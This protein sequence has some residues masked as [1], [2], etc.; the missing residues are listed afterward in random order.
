MSKPV[1]GLSNF[2]KG[3]DPANTAIRPV[4]PGEIEPA[5][6]RL[7]GEPG[8]LAD[9]EAAADFEAA[10]EHRGIDLTRIQLALL[11]EQI[12]ASAL[13]VDSGGSA[14]LLVA[15][16][17]GG[18]RMVSIAAAACV[19][20]CV[21]AWPTNSPL[22]QILLDPVEWR[23]AEELRHRGFE[24]L[25]TLIYMH[26]VLAR[27][28]VRPLTPPGVMLVTDSPENRP[29]F[30]A[31]IEGSYENS[32]DC[33]KLHG[34]RSI[35]EVVAAHQATGEF[36]PNL[37]F[38]L[39]ENSRP[40]GVLL[41]SRLHDDRGLE[42]VYLGLTPAGRGKGYGDYFLQLALAETSLTKG[43]QLTLA[44]DDQNTPAL[45]LYYRHGLS[46]VQGR[47]AMMCTKT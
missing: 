29:L 42:L 7:L 33:P 44:V 25:A 45:K 18:S 14:V 16:A 27:E 46:Q 31:A 20:A 21:D 36:D 17:A 5:I 32:L 39:V 26:R 15:S 23:T 47:L 43:K 9:T 41:L 11:D 4:G 10:A 12:I 22:F 13:P 24:D 35:E 1:R 37:W 28:I 40:L 30:K 34:R 3:R 38:C 8:Q 6:R 19:R 2:F